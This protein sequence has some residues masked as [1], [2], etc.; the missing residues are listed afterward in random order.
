MQ[1]RI[2]HRAG[3]GGLATLRVGVGPAQVAPPRLAGVGVGAGAPE[4]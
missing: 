3:P 4:P 1:V 2:I